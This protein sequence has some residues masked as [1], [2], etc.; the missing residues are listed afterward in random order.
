MCTSF[1]YQ[2]SHTCIGMNFDISDRRIKLV[3]QKDGQLLVMQE[4]GGQFYPA[5]GINKNGTFMNLQ[6]VEPSEEGKYRRGK[7]CVHIMKL[8]ADVLGEKLALTDVF[9]YVD[10]HAIVN[11]PGHSVHSLIAG[12]GQACVV[13][14]GKK[15]LGSAAIADEPFMVLTNF[16]LFARGEQENGQ[17]EA[18]G[19]DRYRVARERLL[20]V[21]EPFEP[22]AAFSILRETAQHGGAFPTQLSLV[23]VA[24][25]G[26]VYFTL[27]ADFA[28]VLRFS[29]HDRLIQTESGFTWH[30]QLPLT[31]RGVLISELAGW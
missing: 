21:Q 8:F 27:R 14:P 12:M 6:M 5:L 23:A 15:A 16:S 28:K 26:V 25:E 1:V 17:S 22:A 13:E 4:D 31:N 11:V 2:G 7:N 29:F 24:E 18:M 10:Q 19:A 30:R 20:A 9:T 3:C